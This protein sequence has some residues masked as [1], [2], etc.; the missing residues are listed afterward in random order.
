MKSSSLGSLSL[1][2]VIPPDLHHAAL[3]KP[4]AQLLRFRAGEPRGLPEAGMGVSMSF[5]F[6]WGLSRTMGLENPPKSSNQPDMISH[7]CNPSCRE[8]EAKGLL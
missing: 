3:S 8:A 5:V 4:L 1:N 6:P 7:A 2:A